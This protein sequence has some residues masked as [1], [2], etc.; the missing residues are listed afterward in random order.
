MYAEGYK[1]NRRAAYFELPLNP[2]VVALAEE[3][4][5]AHPDV[6]TSLYRFDTAQIPGSLVDGS[7]E[8]AS[9]LV[10]LKALWPWLLEYYSTPLEWYERWISWIEKFNTEHRPSTALPLHGEIDDM[11]DF[12]EAELARLGLLDSPLSSLLRYERDKL[13]A[14]RE[15]TNFP[16]REPQA[17]L[18]GDLT[19]NS[20]VTRGCDYTLSPLDHDLAGLLS[21]GEIRPAVG[22]VAVFAKV[23][24]DELTTL[25]VGERTARILRRAQRPRRIIDLLK[26]PGDATAPDLLMP[27]VRT[28]VQ[29]GLLVRVEHRAFDEGGSMPGSRGEHELQ[30]KFN[31]VARAYAFYNNQMLDHLNPLMRE[32]IARQPLFFLGTSDGRGNCD[33]TL[34]AG[35]PGVMRVLDEHTMI[36]PEYRGNGVMASLGNISENP[37]VGLFFGDFFH[38]TVGL[39]VNGRA[40]LVTHEEIIAELSGRDDLLAAAAREVSRRLEAWVRIEVEEAYIH[41]S[42]HIP[43]LKQL[44]KSLHW[45][46]DDRE[47]KGGDYFHVRFRKT[48]NRPPV[49]T[50]TRTQGGSTC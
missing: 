26:S 7:E 5:S 32:Y 31:N 36:Y 42:K 8:I 23:E 16:G 18:T 48:S 14:S 17:K 45:G 49:P 46:T 1:I 29:R 44:N 38:S 3:L 41:C 2:P 22:Q 9:K 25:Q 50:P 37:H 47:R 21:T 4:R 40:H 39:H 33:C 34:R 13:Y 27:I 19:P 30:E 24:G 20:V 15:L 35:E 10:V 11:M 6:F 28:L 12:I 43:L